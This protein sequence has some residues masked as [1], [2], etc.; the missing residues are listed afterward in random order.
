[1][2]ESRDVV[3]VAVA[4]RPKIYIQLEI[5]RPYFDKLDSFPFRNPISASPLKEVH[6]V[7]N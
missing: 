3:N 6:M 2:I 7:D 4:G 1:L 5:H